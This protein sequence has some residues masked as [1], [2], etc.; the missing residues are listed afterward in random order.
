MGD[1]LRVLGEWITFLWPLK[2][3]HTWQTGLRVAGG[4]IKR[5]VGPGIQFTVPWYHEIHAEAMTRGIVQTPRHDI[6]ASDGTVVSFQVSGWVQLTDVRLAYQTVDSYMETTQ[7]LLSQ[8]VSTK[9]AEVDASRLAPEKRG[10]LLSDLQRWVNAET[11]QFGVEVTGLS[12]TTFV[13]N[14]RIY[15]LLG[16]NAP[17]AEW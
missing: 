2:K 13:V 4:K 3:V 12:F 7:E 5:V 8:I 14:P 6:T 1:L 11:T 10:R 15:R 16:D 17:V 9:L